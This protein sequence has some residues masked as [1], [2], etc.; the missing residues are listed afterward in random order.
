MGGRLARKTG[1]AGIKHCEAQVVPR[2]C[3]VVWEA[4]LR[5]FGGLVGGTTHV[6]KYVR[7][8]PARSPCERLISGED[9]AKSGEQV[10][11]SGEV[12][13]RSGEEWRRSG[14][15]WRRSGEEVAKGG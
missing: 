10:A 14:E 7:G 11:K 9:V 12:C 1:E 5:G 15:E 2:M 6:E 4:M 8:D 3:K 13:R